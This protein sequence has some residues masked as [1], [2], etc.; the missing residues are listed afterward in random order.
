LRDEPGC[1][2]FEQWDDEE[3]AREAQKGS[4]EA[5]NTLFLRHQPLL[6][7]LAYAAKRLLYAVTSSGHASSAIGPEDIDQQAFII[8][9]GLLNTWEPARAPFMHYFP[10]IMHWRLLG[11][12]RDEFHRETTG[13][14]AQDGSLPALIPL[15]ERAIDPQIASDD[16]FGDVEWDQHISRL[17]E[18]LRETISLRFYHDLSS[19]QIA[20]IRGRT[21]RTV[22]RNIQAALSILR[23][24]MVN[25][26]EGCPN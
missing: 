7:K 16:A 24:S 22:N 26:H 13:Y 4:I 20:A 11:Y 14:T 1:Q 6:K 21:R 10:K 12:V 8:F 17:P 2:E 15:E 18:S 25:H 9:C 5:R 19:A 3:L 23:Q